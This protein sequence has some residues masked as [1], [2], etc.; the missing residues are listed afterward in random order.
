MR[1]WYDHKISILHY[2]KKGVNLGVNY[3]FS[4]KMTII[5]DVETVLHEDFI[6]KI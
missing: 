5:F 4:G 6:G 1:N 2:G 3:N